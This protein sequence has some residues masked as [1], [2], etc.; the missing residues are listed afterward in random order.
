M[1]PS[2]IPTPAESAY[3][4]P[5]VCDAGEVVE[6]TLGIMKFDKVDDTQYKHS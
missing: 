5:V 4:P 6:T 3:A 1:E 2:S